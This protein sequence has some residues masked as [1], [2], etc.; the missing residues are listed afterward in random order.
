MYFK[1]FYKSE[2]Y[3]VFYVWM[4]KRAMKSKINV[5]VLSSFSSHSLKVYIDL[6]NVFTLNKILVLISKCSSVLPM[7]L[8]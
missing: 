6:I 7:I 2:R 1:C 8:F 4:N 3:Y 5:T